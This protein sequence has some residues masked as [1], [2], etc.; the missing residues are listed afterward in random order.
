MG[1]AA[2][3]IDR[4]IRETRD[5][6]DENLA[7]LQRRT[8]PN[9]RRY[10]RIALIVI[11]ALAVAGAGFFAYRKVTKRSRIQRLHGMVRDLPD[12]LR[13]LSDPVTSRLKKPLPS[14]RMIVNQESEARS[15]GRLEDIFRRV[16]PAVVG[17]AATAILQRTKRPSNSSDAPDALAD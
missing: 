7:L 8:V 2:D 5:H 1:A 15:E 11:A 14:I 10:G 9:A 17:S 16:A 12:S 13:D 4:Q 3:E 6:M